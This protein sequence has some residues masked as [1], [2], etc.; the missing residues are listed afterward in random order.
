MLY[1]FHLDGPGCPDDRRMADVVAA[2][3]AVPGRE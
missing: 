3:R 1:D 2:D